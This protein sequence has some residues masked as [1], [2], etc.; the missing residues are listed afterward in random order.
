MKG[1]IMFSISIAYKR[2]LVTIVLLSSILAACNGGGL[3]QSTL[4]KLTQTAI[5]ATQTA[6]SAPGS[7]SPVV[8][9]T[10]V[11]NPAITSS[12]LPVVAA[13][14][15]C[16]KEPASDSAFWI[17]QDATF[18]KNHFVPSGYMGDVGDVVINEAHKENP[19][20]G[21]TSMEIVYRPEG[22]G[23]NSCNYAPPCKWA[24][25]YWLD[26]ANN[27]GQDAMWKDKG[28]DLT[29]YNRLVFWARAEQNGEMEF[30]T[31][32]I[33]AP[34]GDSLEYARA[35]IADLTPEWQQFEIDLQD[36]DLSHI[37]GGFVFATSW[38]K[39]PDGITFYLDDVRFEK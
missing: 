11:V 25:V 15:A 3:D 30:K 27:W 10:S 31:G 2:F 6:I 34:Y 13:A 28:F 4:L 20:S 9:A 12:P 23:P 22:K 35:T 7:A 5:A 29:G 21:E 39:N 14:G 1:N 17:Y 32:G 33:V 26:P 19:C 24:G 38:D 18:T 37:I 36:A 16:G 8:S